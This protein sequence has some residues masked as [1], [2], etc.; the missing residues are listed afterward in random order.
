[1]AQQ[2][3]E[4]KK[5]YKAAVEL[6]H[7]RHSVWTAALSNVTA[8]DAA[9]FVGKGEGS[10]MEQLDAEDRARLSYEAALDDEDELRRLLKASEQN[11]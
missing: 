5:R 4:L 7:V 3:E 10:T 1:M 11:A 6:T 8:A 2:D 9:A